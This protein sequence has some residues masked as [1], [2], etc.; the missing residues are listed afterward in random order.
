MFIIALYISKIGVLAFLSRITKDRAQLRI[1]YACY[2]LVVAFGVISLLVVTVGCSWPSGYYWAFFANSIACDSQVS[3]GLY[4]T[5]RKPITDTFVPGCPL[6]SPH[7]P[8]H[9]HRARPPPPTHPP[10]VEATNATNEKS[11]PPHSLLP[12]APRHSPLNRPQRLHFTPPPPE[13]RRQP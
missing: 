4:I 10:R 11:R 7:S 9:H 13:L 8:R 5:L 6:A 1:Y 12:P 3:N 2:W